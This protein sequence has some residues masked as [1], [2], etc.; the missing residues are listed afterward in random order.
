MYSFV[1]TSSLQCQS[2]N[3]ENAFFQRDKRDFFQIEDRLNK[4]IPPLDI[5]RTMVDGER[6]FPCYI[7]VGVFKNQN[8]F[9]P[10]PNAEVTVLTREI[11][12]TNGYEFYGYGNKYVGFTKTLTGDDGM[13]CAPTFCFYEALVF[14]SNGGERLTFASNRTEFLPKDYFYIAQTRNEEVAFGPRYMGTMFG[15]R[16]PV[17][18][19]MNKD[20]CERSTTTNSWYFRFVYLSVPERIYPVENRTSQPLSWYPYTSKSPNFAV[21]F[22]KVTINVSRFVKI[23][24]FKIHL[25]TMDFLFKNHCYVINNA[26]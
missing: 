18:R 10:V 3:K 9:E 20:E 5:T 16:G 17:Y 4:S 19:E 24:L 23:Y 8:S 22:L 6:R 21:C 7:R 13:A 1:I 11:N 2:T 26:N 25:K 15:K 14:V 12:N